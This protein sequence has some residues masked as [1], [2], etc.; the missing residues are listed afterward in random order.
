VGTTVTKSFFN[1][2]WQEV[3]SVTN[4]QVTSYVWGLRYIDDLVLREKGEERL[5]SL[6]DPNW[7]VIAIC[8][9]TG[10]IQERYTYDA[11]GVIVYQSENF[12]EKIHSDYD[13]TYLYATR[14]FDFETGL[15]CNRNRYYHPTLGQFINPDPLR[16]NARDI[17]FFRYVLN[18]P[19]GLVDPW[20]LVKCESTGITPISLGDTKGNSIP[21][22]VFFG[23]RFSIDGVFEGQKC[24]NCCKDG[25][26]VWDESV[27]LSVNF[28]AEGWVGGGGQL[29]WN[30]MMEDIDDRSVVGIEG[31]Y[32]IKGSGSGSVSISGSGSTD[33][34]NG[35]NSISFTPCGTLQIQV[36]I[37]GGFRGSISV[38]GGWLHFVIAGEM[39]GNIT[40]TIQSCFECTESGCSWKYSKP[41]GLFARMGVRVC[42]GA[43]REVLLFNKRII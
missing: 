18:S 22:G 17:N 14:N 1:E 2:N 19:L 21:F 37:T 28:V 3:E 31:Y 32:G 10:D 12:D 6:A 25:S 16:Y 20:G 23:Y 29:V 7:N 35:K 30:D 34:C 39:F 4:N 13:W 15:Y 43:C 41:T 42:F 33:K 8:D 38:L 11:F 27:S 24:K 26:K 40:L 36:G 9:S 5:Y